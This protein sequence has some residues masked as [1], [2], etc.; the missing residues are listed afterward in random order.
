M[1]DTG[2]VVLITL[3]VLIVLPL[4]WGAV[5]MGGLGAGMMGGWGGWDTSWSPWR[6]IVG[7]LSTVAII[8]GIGAIVV[9]V[10][11]RTTQVSPPSGQ[12]SARDLLDARYAQGG[13]TREQYQQMR[14]D[15]ES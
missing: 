1:N 11:G 3:V 14:R 12:P 9:W 7:M 5:M 6:A 13:I 2:R 15:L 8:G 10:F 4:L